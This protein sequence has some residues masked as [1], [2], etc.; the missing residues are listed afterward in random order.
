MR[1]RTAGFSKSPGTNRRWSSQRKRKRVT[2]RDANKGDTHF[3]RGLSQKVFCIYGPYEEL[4]PLWFESSPTVTILADTVRKPVGFAMLGMPS[5]RGQFEFVGELLA[6][7]VEPQEHNMGVGN[8]IMGEVI[9]RAETFQIDMLILHTA[10]ENHAAKRLFLKHG[11]VPGKVKNK[12]Y[13]EG[14]DALMMWRN[15]P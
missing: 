6:I 4:L 10:P 11:F 9:R 1:R 7:A 2:L 8:R 14:Q 12:F 5:R 15:I 3:I 13:S